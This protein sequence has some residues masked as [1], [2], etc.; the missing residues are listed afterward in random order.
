M[1]KE[2]RSISCI[3]E[4]PGL[5]MVKGRRPANDREITAKEIF[6]GYLPRLYLFSS[7]QGYAPYSERIA[8][9]RALFL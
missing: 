6:L 5:L 7:T 8:A 9:A 4:K 1:T 2:T 3:P